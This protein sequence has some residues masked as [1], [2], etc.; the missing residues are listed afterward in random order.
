MQVAMW[1]ARDA[2]EYKH[3]LVDQKDGTSDVIMVLVAKGT[4]ARN[5]TKIARQ[6]A[7]SPMRVSTG[8]AK[9]DPELAKKMGIDIQADLEGKSDKH[10]MDGGW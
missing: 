6:Y 2:F 5:W 1:P 9:S 4:A 3:L 8:L 10:V 7:G